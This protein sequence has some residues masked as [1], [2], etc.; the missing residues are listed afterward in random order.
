MN[1]REFVKNIIG[2]KVLGV[3]DYYRFREYRDSWGGPFNAQ[4]FR[5]QIFLELIQKVKFSAI[6]ETGT[7]RGTTTEYFSET[8]ALPV[9]TVELNPRY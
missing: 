4:A 1:L 5:Q 2:A 8:S 3:A 9:H 7:F 6:A